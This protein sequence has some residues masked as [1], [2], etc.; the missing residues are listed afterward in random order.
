MPMVSFAFPNLLSSFAL[1]EV[2]VCSSDSVRD[3]G[4][5][6]RPW[7]SSRNRWTKATQPSTFLNGLH[8]SRYPTRQ[9]HQ[10]HKDMETWA[11]A[12]CLELARNHSIRVCL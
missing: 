2:N 12:I 1:Q 3:F 9:L 5:S 4:M 10:A 7:N 11:R 6:P 8:F